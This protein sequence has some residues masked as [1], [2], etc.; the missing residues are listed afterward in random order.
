MSFLSHRARSASSDIDRYHGDPPE[1][2]D[3]SAVGGIP[4]DVDDG[5]ERAYAD[6]STDK[7]KEARKKVSHQP[8]R[9]RD[10]M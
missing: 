4:S 3:S 9:E 5:D 8:S 10:L 6:A 1:S 2:D 7:A